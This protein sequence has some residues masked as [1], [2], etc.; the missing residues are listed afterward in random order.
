MGNNFRVSSSYEHVLLEAGSGDGLLTPI[1][2]KDLAHEIMRHCRSACRNATVSMLLKFHSNLIGVT[3]TRHQADELH[4][5]IEQATKPRK[6]S[7]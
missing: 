1:E 4:D 6:V 5:L 2:G 3:F 7:A